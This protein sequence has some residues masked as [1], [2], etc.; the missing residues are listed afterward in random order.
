MNVISEINELPLIAPQPKAAQSDRRPQDRRSSARTAPDFSVEQD[1][2]RR[3]GR[4][5]RATARLEV[6]IDFEERLGDSRY[7]R[8]TRDLSTFGLSTRCGYPHAIGTKFDLRLFLPDA[9]ASQPV[10]VA[11]EVVGY[12]TFDGGMRLAFRKPPIE[13]V[14]RIHRYLGS[15]RDLLAA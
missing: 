9:P 12:D 4:E 1:S 6:E 8:V 11:A 13:A 15:R 3:A 5:R 2:D 7:F 14:K 10:V